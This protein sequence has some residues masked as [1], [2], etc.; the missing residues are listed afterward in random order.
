M[1]HVTYPALLESFLNDT[2]KSEINATKV[3][4][5]RAW[6]IGSFVICGIGFLANTLTIAVILRG[7]PRMSVFMALLL[8][9]A[10][11]DNVFLSTI[12]LL[13]TRDALHITALSSSLLF[14][15]LCILMY[16]T[17][18]IISSWLLVCIALERYI[19]VSY[20]LKAI[21]YCTKKRTY[22]TILV[23]IIFSLASGVPILFTCSIQKVDLEGRVLCNIAGS[24]AIFDFIVM[25][26]LDLLYTIIPFVT[27]LSLNILIVRKI[28]A[29]NKLRIQMLGHSRTLS[30]SETQIRLV[31]MM[32]SVCLLFALTSF[33]ASL[34]L[35]FRIIC[36]TIKGEKCFKDD[37]LVFLIPSLLDDLNHTMNF[38]LYCITG[39]VFRKELVNFMKWRK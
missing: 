25:I 35:S 1:E 24:N 26:V 39:S 36:S 32:V 19:A 5:Y 14:C 12:L 23:I 22:V 33:S 28:R 20:P 17:T 11:T 38:F 15:R 37:D 2:H 34:Y 18:G 27:M 6:T 31:P 3:S 13:R 10:I 7:F 16:Y 30:S 9:L 4:I 29:T 21:T 8:F